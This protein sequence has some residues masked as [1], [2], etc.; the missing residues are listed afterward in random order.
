MFVFHVKKKQNPLFYWS[1]PNFK[2]H[3]AFLSKRKT[4]LRL[5][6]GVEVIEA[7]HKSSENHE[8]ETRNLWFV[9]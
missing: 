8:R 3:S 4:P 6:A 1:G 7:K 9:D 2:G 5:G